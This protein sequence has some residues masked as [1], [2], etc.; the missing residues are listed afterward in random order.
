MEL[1]DEHDIPPGNR[2]GARQ[3]A[4]DHPEV[5]HD[6]WT[7]EHGRGLR[8]PFTF[9]GLAGL[10]A[11]AAGCRPGQG[12]ELSRGRLRITFGPWTL[13]T[14]LD[15]VADAEVTG[16]YQLWKVVGPPHLSAADRGIAFS[17]NTEAGVCLT[18]H[19]PV[20]AALPI[21][22]L[23]HPGATVTVEDPAGLVRAVHDLAAART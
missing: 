6:V 7:V 4:L 22:L 19:Q 2:R 11:R 3:P 15:N 17:T 13:D 8:F 23:R 21:G 12:V 16:P 20:P 10:A 18:F 1:V 9:V 14:P 5:P